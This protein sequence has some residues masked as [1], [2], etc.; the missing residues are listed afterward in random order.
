MWGNASFGLGGADHR[1]LRDMK[2][3]GADDRPTERDEDTNRKSMFPAPKT[4]HSSHVAKFGDKF[5]PFPATIVA[6][7]DRALDFG[8]SSSSS[9]QS[10]PWRLSLTVH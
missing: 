2:S 4:L 10:V 5:S 6:N 3:M 9:K 8:S 1:G 7:V